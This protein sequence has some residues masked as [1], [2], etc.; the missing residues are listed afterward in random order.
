MDRLATGS[1][2]VRNG[3][4]CL[5]ERVCII[6][7]PPSDDYKRSNV[8]VDLIAAPLCTVFMYISMK[9]SMRS[10][11]KSGPVPELVTGTTRSNPIKYMYVARQVT[12]VTGLEQ[13]F[14]Q[15]SSLDMLIK[16]CNP[17]FIQRCL[18]HVVTVSCVDLVVSL[19][20]MHVVY[21]AWRFPDEAVSLQSGFPLEELHP[22]ITA[23]RSFVHCPS[24]GACNI[25]VLSTSSCWAGMCSAAACRPGLEAELGG[26]RTVRHRIARQ[27]E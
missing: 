25:Q 10:L 3:R 9:L 27:T 20:M 12:H 6:S 24:T 8:L 18:M 21:R 15:L 14:V 2:V 11:Y 7:S 23:G 17:E 16:S 22:P 26:L 5:Q 13:D 19:L 1:H 4:L